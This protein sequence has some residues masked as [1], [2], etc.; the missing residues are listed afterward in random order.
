MQ[1]TL[2]GTQDIRMREL[3]PSPQGT[4][5][6]VEEEDSKQTEKVIEIRTKL[7]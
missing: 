1:G 3:H 2:P 5:S 4:L 7:Y 6:L